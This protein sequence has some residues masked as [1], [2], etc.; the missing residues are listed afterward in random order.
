MGEELLRYAALP[1][2]RVT[3]GVT[4]E[5]QTAVVQVGA[6]PLLNF[7][8]FFREASRNLS[9]E[10]PPQQVTASIR[11]LPVDQF[12]NPLPGGEEVL[13]PSGG[14]VSV[15]V[16]GQYYVRIGG[17]AASDSGVY[18]IEVCSQRGLPDQ[19]CLNASATLLVLDGELACNH[20][21]NAEL[22]VANLFRLPL[23]PPL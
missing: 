4:Q 1:G 12:G 16:D 2:E 15:S 20:L 3:V 14:R 23:L 19:V 21:H 17:A 8:H 9:R 6:Q 22:L 7:N 13:P 5:T 10:E 11:R 18:T